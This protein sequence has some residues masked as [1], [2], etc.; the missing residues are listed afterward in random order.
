MDENRPKISI[1]QSEVLA[2]LE[3]LRQQAFDELLTA[4]DLQRVL[5]VSR[6]RAYEL[7]ASG[8]LPTVQIGRLRRVSARALNEWIDNQ[9]TAGV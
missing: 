3:A 5:K 9:M 1:A 2:I 6:A 4:T 8:E 7:M